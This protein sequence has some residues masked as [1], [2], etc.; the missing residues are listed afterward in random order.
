MSL[1]TRIRLTFTTAHQRSFRSNGRWQKRKNSIWP[2]SLRELSFAGN[3]IT[4]PLCF[5]HSHS[6][7]TDD[8][9]PSCHDPKGPSRVSACGCVDARPLSYGR[10]EKRARERSRGPAERREARHKSS[11]FDISDRTHDDPSPTT[12]I[13]FAPFRSP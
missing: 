13:L 2:R 6:N 11:A 10:S 3:G 1:L 12:H 7:H 8:S 5:R 9:A 4:F